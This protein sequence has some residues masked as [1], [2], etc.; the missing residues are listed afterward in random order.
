MKEL[1]SYELIL[2][3]GKLVQEKP[4]ANL[5]VGPLSYKG[6]QK[7]KEKRNQLS[8]QFHLMWI[9]RRLRMK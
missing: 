3:D 6:K 4:K 8:I 2:N 1:Q 5:V 7:A 9:G